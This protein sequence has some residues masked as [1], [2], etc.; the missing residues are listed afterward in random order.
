M[1]RVGKFLIARP[2]IE[3]GFFA[4][5]IVFI[6][7]DTARGTA[8]LTINK[9]CGLDFAQIAVQRGQDYAP[10]QTP[11]YKGGPVNENSITLLH[12][13]DFIS[14][15]TLHTGTGLDVSSDEIMIQKIID[16]NTPR[17]F[18]VCAGASIWAPG[19]LDFEIKKNYWLVTEL[20]HS[21]VFNYQPG[22]KQW[23][24]AINYTGQQFV[25]RYF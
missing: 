14:K 16:G 3:A 7:E 1:S 22:D 24:S 15:N 13:D 21:I 25:Q 6:Y 11:I 23:E 2:N 20:D 10:G 17:G 18:R 5:S 8:G 4:R 19:Q 12:T 9:P